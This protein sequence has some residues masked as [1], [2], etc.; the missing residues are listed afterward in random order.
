[1]QMPPGWFIFCC[2]HF[3]PRPISSDLA[4][5]SCGPIGI[6]PK[7][8][9][10]LPAAVGRDASPDLTANRKHLSPAIYCPTD[11]RCLTA[12]RPI[13]RPTSYLHIHFPTALSY[14]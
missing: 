7:S 9:S 2:P 14:I 13:Y 3:L 12:F 6:L 1:M 8:N 4:S 5:E 11:F 10:V